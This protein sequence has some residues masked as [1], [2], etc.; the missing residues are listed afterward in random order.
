MI[1][2][3]QLIIINL[4]DYYYLSDFISL[5]FSLICNINRLIDNVTIIWHRNYYINHFIGWNLDVLNA[6]IIVCFW[7]RLKIND[8][9]PVFMYIHV[10]NLH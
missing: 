6:K 3:S 9:L 7:S 8:K 4:N 2:I 1:P 10:V 5:Q